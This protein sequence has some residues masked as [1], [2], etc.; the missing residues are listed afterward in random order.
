VEPEVAVRALDALDAAVIA[1]SRDLHAVL[2]ANAV[3]RSLLVDGQ[4]AAS[5]LTAAEGYIGARPDANRPP[6]AIRIEHGLRA[7]YVRAVPSAGSPPAEI[8]MVREEVLRDVDVFKML[9]AQYRITRREFQILSSLRLGKTNRQIA[10]DLGLAK[11]TV[12]RHVHRMLERFSAP[13]RTRLV[14]MVDRLIAR[15]G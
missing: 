9:N 15:R 6:P 14:D 2:H 3:A 7:F 10:G 5:I 1:Y 12:A 4:L 11:G 8:V 13:N